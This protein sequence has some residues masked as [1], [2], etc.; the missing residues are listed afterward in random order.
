M[1]R[2]MITDALRFWELGRIPYNLIL[3]TIVVATVGPQAMSALPLNAWGLLAVLGVIA[4]ML[5]CAAYPVDLFLQVSAW[6][7]GW[8][9]T[10]MALWL[11]GMF[12]AAWF[13]YNLCA[14]L[15]ATP[16]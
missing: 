6:R 1:A 9:Q 8:R 12:V 11:V 13:T 2:T 15:A 14:G 3:L 10:R 7:E 4:N 16:L 5:Y